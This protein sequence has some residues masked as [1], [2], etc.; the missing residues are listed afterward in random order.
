MQPAQKGFETA[1]VQAL[2]A[3]DPARPVLVEAESARIGTLRLPPALWAAMKDS[4]R[5][6]VEAPVEARAAFLAK[7]IRRARRRCPGADGA[8]E[9]PAG[10][11]GA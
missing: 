2:D 6:V 4:P 7:R 9:R 8:V 5:I 10:D 3:L 11:R 1:L